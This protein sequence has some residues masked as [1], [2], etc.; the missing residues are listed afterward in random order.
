MLLCLL[1]ALLVLPPTLLILA[2]PQP[3]PTPLP[4]LF[5]TCADTDSCQKT[6]REVEKMEKGK[7]L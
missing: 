6:K 1:A 2:L 7:L 4:T 3:S 5:S